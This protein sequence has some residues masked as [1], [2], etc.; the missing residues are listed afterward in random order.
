MNH[1]RY[2]FLFF[3]LVYGCGLFGIVGHTANT[4]TVSTLDNL[5]CWTQK[6]C[7]QVVGGKQQGVW[8]NLSSDAKNECPGY[9]YCF[10][11]KEKISVAIA[12]PGTG[13]AVVKVDDVGNYIQVFYNF[14]LGLGIVITVIMGMVGGIQYILASGSPQKTSAAVERIEK[15]IIGLVLLFCAVI[16]LFTVNPELISLNLPK[17]PKVRQ[18]IFVSDETPCEDL[19]DKNTKEGTKYVLDPASGSCG[20]PRS[21]VIQ[22][23]NGDPITDTQCRWTDCSKS[24][25]DSAGFTKICSEVKGKDQCIACTDIVARN[26]FEITPSSGIC[27]SLTP[28]AKQGVRSDQYVSCEFSRDT[29]FSQWASTLGST[30]FSGQCALVSINCNQITSCEAYDNVQVVNK[31]GSEDLDSFEGPSALGDDFSPILKIC[32]QNICSNYVEG[33]VKNA[34]CKLYEGSTVVECVSASDS[35]LNSLT[36]C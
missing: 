35:C 2:F 30:T 21:K 36:G 29:G 1:H 18:I 7:E 13:G 5:R 19:L 15:S 25:K 10:P 31:D 34:P 14:L 32:D 26:N 33:K 11:V 3:T 24:A 16:I 8:D 23:A 4:S 9:G 28:R 22:D 12:I 17:M 6:S 20:S 27:S